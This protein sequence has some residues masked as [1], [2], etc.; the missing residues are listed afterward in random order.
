MRGHQAQ[1]RHV[2]ADGLAFLVGPG[3]DQLIGGFERDFVI[4]QA[5]PER[6]ERHDRGFVAH[7]GAAHFKELL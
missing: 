4:E 5:R 7:I 3:L 2:A 1:T 6:R